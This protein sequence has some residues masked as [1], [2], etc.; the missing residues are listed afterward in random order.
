MTQG[1]VLEAAPQDE[2][3]ERVTIWPGNP[4][5]VPIGLHP[6]LATP[7][8]HGTHDDQQFWVEDRPPGCLLSDLVAA[9]APHDAARIASQI[10]EGLAALHHRGFTHGHLDAA[11]VVLDED[12]VPV[13]IGAGVRPGTPEA[14]LDAMLALCAQISPTHPALAASTMAEL[15]T[16]LRERALNSPR[17]GVTLTTLLAQSTITPPDTCSTLTLSLQPLGFT[18]E[19]R[20]E[21]GPDEAERGLL[22]RWATE[23]VSG[24]LTGD[25]TESISTTE[26]AAQAKRVLLERVTDLYASPELALRFDKHAG[27]SCTAM[28]ALLTDEP[29]DPL[30]TPEGVVLLQEPAGSGPESTSEITAEAPDVF[31][32][33]PTEETTGWT[34]AVENTATT[35]LSSRWEWALA[36]ALVTLVILAFVSLIIFYVLA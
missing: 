36:G 35:G 19:V 2:P 18:D 9:P 6:V 33:H 27:A 5:T 22:D 23:E 31:E 21:L 4:P 32:P 16:A 11:R 15:S 26:L 12:G 28:F 14:D 17:Q 1:N 34:D 30:P 7:I 24:D 3:E 8:G 25:Q 20:V 10:A 13:L 29:L